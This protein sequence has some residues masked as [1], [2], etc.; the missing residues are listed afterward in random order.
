MTIRPVLRTL[1]AGVVVAL[2]AA[3]C[4]DDDSDGGSASPSAATGSTAAANPGPSEVATDKGVDDTEIRLGVLNDFSGPIAAVGT[5]YATGAEVYFA[6]VNDAGGICERDV[7][8][9]RGDTKYDPQVA[10]QEYR[11][12]RDDI[13]AVVEV[14]GAATI[15]G[16]AS[17]FARDGILVF[18]G[19]DSGAVLELENVF[20]TKTP[21]APQVFNAVSWAVDALAGDDGTLQVGIIYQDDAYGQEG[22]AAL[23]AAA[24]SVEGV[25][26]VAKAGYA[27]SDQD[28]TAQIQ[29]MRDAGAEVVWLHATPRQTPGIVG[30]AA[31]LGYEPVFIGN[32]GAYVPALAKALG[33]LLVDFRHATAIAVWGEDVPGMDDLQAA[34]AEHAPDASPD[35]FITRGWIDASVMAAVLAR[36]CENG[37]LTRAGIIAAMEGLEVDLQGMGANVRISGSEPNEKIPAR[38]SRVLEIDPETGL[39][40][41]VSDWIESDLAVGWELP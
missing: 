10:V 13:A 18:A 3:A 31:Q 1:A 22:L 24:E 28:F 29:T 39:S 7:T 11:A 37:D 40:S 34:L 4:G 26:L 23:E 12:I 2:V 36:A 14:V 20:T 16:L 35:D 15:F 30:G 25:E 17:D 21:A 38:S 33:D 9:V 41:P 19:S 5:A 6:E 8:L 27:T 32:E